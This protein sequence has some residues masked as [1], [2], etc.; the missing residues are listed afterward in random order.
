MVSESRQA[1]RRGCPAGLG[2]AAAVLLLGSA[3]AFAQEMDPDTRRAALDMAAEGD[4]AWTR[5][6]FPASLERFT[7]AR[8]L[9]PAPTLVFRQGECLEKLGRLVDAANVFREAAGFPLAANASEPF[10]KAVTAARVRVEALQPRIPILEIVVQADPS[11]PA[12]VALDGQALPQERWALPMRVDP[13]AHLVKAAAGHVEASER[14]VLDEG[15]RVRIVLHLE[16][17]ANVVA[18]APAPAREAE[19]SPAKPEERRGTLRPWAW[20]GLGIGAAGTLTGLGTG[21]AVLKMRNDLDDGGC[22]SSVCKTSQSG[23]VRTY[24]ALRTASVAGFVVGGLGLVTG[25]ILWFAEPRGDRGNRQAFLPFVA[26]G[27]VGVAGT[28]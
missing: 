2:L 1:I 27:S 21:I 20:V 19:T 18:A 12:T 14:V 15:A 4:E 3:M 13:G 8:A 7:Q 25:V 26:P 9:V 11:G 17:P 22:V 10:R 28:F 6:D 16:P 23:D 5:G 24:N